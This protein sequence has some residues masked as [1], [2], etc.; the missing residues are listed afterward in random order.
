MS[1]VVTLLLLALLIALPV[2]A[3]PA[4]MPK[5]NSRARTEL[6]LKLKRDLEARGASDI[7]WVQVRELGI[8]L[9]QCR[10]EPIQDNERLS[11]ESWFDRRLLGAGADE[12]A[13]LQDLIAKIDQ[14][15]AEGEKIEAFVW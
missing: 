15:R 2:E 6:R 10:V 12:I 11:G 3:A 14:R 9:V 5:T 7:R 4:P 8:Y 13:A 1:K